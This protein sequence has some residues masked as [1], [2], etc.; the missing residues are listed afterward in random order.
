MD[1][2]GVGKGVAVGLR[3]SAVELVDF[4]PPEWIAELALGDIP[5]VVTPDH[6]V[7]APRGAARPPGH[8]RVAGIGGDHG[9]VGDGVGG[10]GDG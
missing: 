7:D 1:L 5:Q 8:V 9:D 3:V 4:P 2:V 10:H 6:T